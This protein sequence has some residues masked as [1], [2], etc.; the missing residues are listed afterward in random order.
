MNSYDYNSYYAVN[1]DA[2]TAVTGIFASMGIIMFI[3]LAVSIFTLVCMWRIF[4]K[5]GKEGWKSLIPIYNLIVLLEIVELPAWYII[6]YLVPIANI[7]VTFK[8][9]IELAHKFGKSTGFGVAT[10]FFNFICLPILAFS[11]KCEYQGNINQ[12]NET[13]WRVVIYENRF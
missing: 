9:Y 6:L 5:A 1:T 13:C 4:T 3:S 8:I 2:T 7:Y 10:V 11:K 12:F